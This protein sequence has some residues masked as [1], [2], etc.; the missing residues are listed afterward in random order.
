MF[1]FA[2]LPTSSLQ[3]YHTPDLQVKEGMDELGVVYLSGRPEILQPLVQCSGFTAVGM[4]DT[5]TEN[6]LRKKGSIWPLIS[7]YSPHVVVGK[8]RYKLKAFQPQARTE[9]IDARILPWLLAFL[10][11]HT[12]GLSLG[13]GVTPMGQA[14]LYQ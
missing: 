3:V 1:R 2:R 14:L 4:P 6:N 7:G 13:N 8:S 10:L 12:S 5:P 11:L 9:S